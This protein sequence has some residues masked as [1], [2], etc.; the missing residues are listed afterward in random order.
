VT[1]STREEQE[2]D[3]KDQSQDAYQQDQ[4]DECDS[5][6][7]DRSKFSPDLF[8]NLTH[9]VIAAQFSDCCR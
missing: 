5:D 9:H 1:L 3:D 2:H 4:R 8:E 6:K 7:K